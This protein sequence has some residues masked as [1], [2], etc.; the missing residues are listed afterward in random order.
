MYT[1]LPFIHLIINIFASL[2]TTKSY[3]CLM[4]VKLSWTFEKCSPRKLFN[5]NYSPS[6]VI[7]WR[8]WRRPAQFRSRAIKLLKHGLLPFLNYIYYDS[9]SSHS[10]V[11]W[12]IATSNEI[13]SPSHI[14]GSRSYHNEERKK[15]LKFWRMRSKWTEE[16]QF[17]TRPNNNQLIFFP[18][19]NIQSNRPSA[20]KRYVS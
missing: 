16:S 6:P 1:R 11:D 17:P 18:T 14:S 13:V 15:K 20:S 2:L 10:R 7:P 3:K 8:M 12:S 4:N 9:Y 19:T 5:L